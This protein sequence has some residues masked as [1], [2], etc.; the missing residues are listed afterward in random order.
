MLDPKNTHKKKIWTHKIPMKKNLAPIKQSQENCGPTKHP[1]EK[2]LDPQ[3]YDST[4]PR[5]FSTL[6][7]NTNSV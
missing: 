2:F 1:K 7:K 4:R 3:R 6:T 5:E